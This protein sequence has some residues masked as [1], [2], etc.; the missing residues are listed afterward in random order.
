MSGA[1]FTFT[2]KRTALDED[3]RP[4]ENTRITTNFANLARG[5]CRQENLRNTLS[6]IDNRFNSLMDQ[7]IP[8]VTVT[9]WSSRSSPPRCVSLREKT[10]TP[11]R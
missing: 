10:A 2:I 6:M 8:R 7:T 11:S 3:Y 5:D 1:G 9:R 4:A